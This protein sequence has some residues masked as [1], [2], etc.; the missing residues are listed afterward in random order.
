MEIHRFRTPFE[1]IAEYK[2]EVKLYRV[3]KCSMN[4]FPIWSPKGDMVAECLNKE[5]AEEITSA[6]NLNTAKSVIKG[7]Y[8]DEIDGYGLVCPKCNEWVGERVNEDNDGIYKYSINYKYCPECGQKLEQEEF[9]EGPDVEV[10]NSDKEM[11]CLGCS[12]GKERAC[13][14]CCRNWDNEEEE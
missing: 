10:D 4:Y 8:V 13:A 2:E 12:L 5:D 9:G 6:L 3:G 7:E 1:N 14:D 11:D